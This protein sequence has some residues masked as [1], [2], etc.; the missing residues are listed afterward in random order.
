MK[1]HELKDRLAEVHKNLLEFSTRIDMN[2]AGAG[3][4][5]IPVDGWTDIGHRVRFAENPLPAQASTILD[6]V[7]EPGGYIDR[8]NHP[9]HE[10]TVFVIEGSIGDADTGVIVK[11]GGLYIFPAGQFHTISSE[12]GARIVVIFRPKMPEEPK[13]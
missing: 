5:Y 11:E 6:V 10:E 1:S 4:K 9:H 3:R 7:F 12:N 13:K 2:F 8:H